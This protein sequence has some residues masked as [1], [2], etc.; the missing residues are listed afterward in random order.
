ME[1]KKKKVVK[2]KK[3]KDIDGKLLLVRVGNEDRPA[4]DREIDDIKKQI[5]ALLE[6]NS[7]EC[8]VFVTHHA[9]DIKIVEKEEHPKT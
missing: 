7:V 6:E 4:T 1:P 8:L 2:I 5:T 3:Y 9:V